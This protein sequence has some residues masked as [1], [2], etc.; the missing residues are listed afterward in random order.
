MTLLMYALFNQPSTCAQT[1]SFTRRIE[2][3]AQVDQVIVLM[4]SG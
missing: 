4:M 3:G 2:R 1:A